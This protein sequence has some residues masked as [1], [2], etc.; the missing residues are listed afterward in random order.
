M[1]KRPIA[2]VLGAGASKPYGFPTARVLLRDV[3][4][5]LNDQ[6]FRLR[7]ISADY[8]EA[9]IKDLRE[10]LAGSPVGSVDEFL[11]LP[12]HARLVGVGKAAIAASLLPRELPQNLLPDAEDDDWYEY[13]FRRMKEGASTLDDF[14]QNGIAF[15]TFNYDRSL[16]HFLLG[17]LRSTYGATP[18]QVAEAMKR[19]R[20]QIAHVYGSFG[21]FPLQGGELPYGVQPNFTGLLLRKA[22]DSI[23]IVGEP[24]AQAGIDA[25]EALLMP[26]ERVCFLGFGY[27][28]ANVDRLSLATTLRTEAQVFGSAYDLLDGERR[29][30]ARVFRGTGHPIALLGPASDALTTLREFPVLSEFDLRDV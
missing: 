15:V 5:G 20:L 21:A 11:E 6:T 24:R 27:R 14:L 2:L 26:C 12:A 19:A 8:G 3:R 25:A 29:E 1:I 4:R 17:A 16:E 18:A 7:L 30:V 13:L 28:R 22:A 9:E 10:A 23:H